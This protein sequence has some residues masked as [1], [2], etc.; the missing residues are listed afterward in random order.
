LTHLHL[1]HRKILTWV[2]ITA[3]PSTG[4]LMSA[5]CLP[6]IDLLNQDYRLR[7]RL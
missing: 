4:Y 6:W 7:E 5:N 1:S 2:T 3:I